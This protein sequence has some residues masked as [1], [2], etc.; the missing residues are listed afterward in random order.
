MNKTKKQLALL[1]LITI[2][3]VPAIHKLT[4]PIPPEWFKAKFENSLLGN[5]PKAITISYCIIILL[6]LAGPLF[7]LI[8]LVQISLNNAYEQWLRYG[9]TVYCI[10]FIVLTFGSFL[11]QDYDNGFKD[12]MYFTA[13]LLIDNFL[14]DRSKNNA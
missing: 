6:E 3:L 12:F 8:S 5:I 14:F 2:L 1:L 13:V 4:S 10:L 7:L 11:V 9:F